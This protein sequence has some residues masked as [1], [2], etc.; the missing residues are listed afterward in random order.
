MFY[1]IKGHIELCCGGCK[2]ILI[3]PLGCDDELST[4]LCDRMRRNVFNFG[5]FFGVWSL[6]VSVKSPLPHFCFFFIFYFLSRP[7]PPPAIPPVSHRDPGSGLGSVTSFFSSS[8]RVSASSS[9]CPLLVSDSSW[10]V[11][12]DF[13]YISI[14]SLTVRHFHFIFNNGIWGPP[15]S[16]VS[17]IVS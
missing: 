3:N 7:L 6:S 17:C 9:P 16:L 11:E 10:K 1:L 2:H 12:K 13:C 8:R 15:S 5:L 4:W 14:F